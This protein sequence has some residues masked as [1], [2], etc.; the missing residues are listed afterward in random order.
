MIRRQFITLLG[1]AAA[2]PRTARAQQSQRMRRIGVLMSLGEN[3][4]ESH[5]RIA[6]LRRGLEEFGWKENQ[7]VRI[8]YRFSG[9]AGDRL[10]AYAAEMVGTAPDVLVGVT[11]PTVAA[12][13]GQTSSIP[14]VFVQVADPVASGFVAS[15]ARPGGNATGFLNFEFSMGGKWLGIIKELSPRIT[16]VVALFNPET[17]P[18]AVHFLRS[19]EAS[20]PTFS[21][22]LSAAPVHNAAEIERAID[23]SAPNLYSGLIA[24]PDVSMTNHRDL[25]IALAARNQ[26]PA[27]YPFRYFAVSGGL[28]SYGS[29]AIDVTRRAAG[30]VDRILRGT[31]PADLPVQAPI[32]FELVINLRTAKALG[33]TVPLALQAAADEVIE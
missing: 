26:L 28:L 1:S 15:L 7:N 10:Q 12:L 25:I 29:D 3:D 17:A 21:I 8:E 23:A 32:K 16:R 2:W 19:L 13:R 24:L 33:L 30:Y 18:Y 14:I 6:A 20:S 11:T 22:E 5:A 27:V 31:N 4:P 9:G